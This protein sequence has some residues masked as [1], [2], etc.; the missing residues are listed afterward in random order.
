MELLF[1]GKYMGGG[2]KKNYFT[3]WGSGF[4]ASEWLASL[5]PNLITPCSVKPEQFPDRNFKTGCLYD[6][7][8]L[9]R[10]IFFSR[11]ISDWFCLLQA[12]ASGFIYI[13]P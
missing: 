6:R 7:L 11:K 4:S 13:S 10:L 1:C 9:W 12:K 5:P 2:E 8:F 3:L